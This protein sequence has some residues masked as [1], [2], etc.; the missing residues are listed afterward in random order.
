[1]SLLEQQCISNQEGL[2]LLTLQ[3]VATYRNELRCP[4]EVEGTV[5][6]SY[7]FIFNDFDEAMFF[8]NEVA[9][10]AESE[11]HHP[12]IHV[13]FKRVI[14]ELTTH[15]VHGLSLNDFILASKIETCE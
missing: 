10:V 12:D 7:E 5:K 1:M 13:Y 8:V 3:E 15:A 9:A 14:I 2:K 4:W 11:D 6:I